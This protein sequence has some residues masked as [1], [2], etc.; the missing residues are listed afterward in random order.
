MV[1]TPDRC[2]L[3]FDVVFGDSGLLDPSFSGEG[4]A[5]PCCFDQLGVTRP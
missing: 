5:N 1:C 4:W 2:C 3:V